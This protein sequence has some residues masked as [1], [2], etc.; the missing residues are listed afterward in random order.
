MHNYRLFLSFLIVSFFFNGYSQNITSGKIQGTV[1]EAETGAILPW[2]SVM[3]QGTV[4]GTSS[5]SEGKFELN[6]LDPGDYTLQFRLIGYEN[7]IRE[8]ISVL[9]GETVELTIQ[10]KETTLDAPEV[11]VTASKRAQPIEDLHTSIAVVSSK[12]L[13]QKN[14]V[15][16]NDYLENV[17]GVNFVGS[18]INIRGS[19]GFSYGVGSRVLLLVDGVPTMTADNG[20]IKWNF[21]PTDQIERVEIVKSAGSALYGSSALGGV[22]N[23]ITKKTTR[24]PE[25]HINLSTGFYDNPP[26]PEWKWTSDPMYFNDLDINHSRSIGNARVFFALGGHQSTGYRENGGYQR[27]NGSGKAIFQL[28]SL[29]KLTLQS[30]LDYSN[31]DIGIM[32]HNRHQALSVD[33]ES[34]GDHSITNRQ[35]LNAIHEWAVNKRLGLKSRIS[36]FRNYYQ[37]KMHDN[38]DYS[39]AQRFGGEIQGTLLAS[40][41]QTLIFGVEQTLDHVSSNAL[42]LHNIFT[43]SAYYQQEIRVLSNFIMTIGGRFDY[44]DTDNDKSY[45]QVSPKGGLVWHFTEYATLRLS[46]GKGFR[47]PSVTEMFPTISAAGLNVIPNLNLKPETGWS[48]EIGIATPIASFLLLDAAVFQNDFWDL[49][50]PLPD[51]D[52]NVQFINVT[53]ARIRGIETNLQ[54]AFFDQRLTGKIG[55]TTLDPQDLEMNTTLAYRSKNMWN[56]S[57]SGI[58]HQF[59][60]GVDYRHYDRIEVVKVYPGDPRVA[61]KVLDARVSWKQPAYSISLNLNNALNHMHTQVER[62]I[63]PIRHLVLT[64]KRKI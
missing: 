8:H 4:L 32:W 63:L 31:S 48:H 11:V 38:N 41:F 15:Y 13:Q 19:S 51:A 18:Q 33:P 23:I 6:R 14:Q 56:I 60:L 26:Y 10:M 40:D 49:I 1:Y 28:S 57:V 21:I 34:L 17:S 46:S 37:N 9:Q 27:L 36:Y 44:S 5:D 2:V 50:E 16:L 64:F 62:T 20:E 12:E 29:Q 30:Q 39:S 59:E 53:R 52:N 54:F 45:Q 7:I 47:A 55:Y 43:S 24:K 35:T 22:I 58:V 25:T 42:G 3:V 61:Q